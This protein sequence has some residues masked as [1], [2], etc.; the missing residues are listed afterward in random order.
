MPPPQPQP[1]R[2]HTFD[3]STTMLLYNGSVGSGSPSAARVATRQ[4]HTVGCRRRRRLRPRSTTP[5]PS[6]TGY[7]DHTW[8]QD[9]FTTR[10]RL[11]EVV[12][13]SWLSTEA[14]DGPVSGPSSSTTAPRLAT[15]L[16]RQI[17]AVRHYDQLPPVSCLLLLPL[18]C[19]RSI[20]V[21]PSQFSLPPKP[22]RP[23]SPPP[24]LP[25]LSALL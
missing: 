12:G 18:S 2:A 16:N 13:P 4:A 15:I 1:A 24:I 17:D 7:I 3:L 21:S 14:H 19:S 22:L 23:P 10:V 5:T 11:G 9:P 25:P 6:P 8:S 20:L